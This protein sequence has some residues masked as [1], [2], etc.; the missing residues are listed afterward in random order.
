MK[1]RAE[2]LVKRLKDEL[3]RSKQKTEKIRKMESILEEIKA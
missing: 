2:Q 3:G 1:I